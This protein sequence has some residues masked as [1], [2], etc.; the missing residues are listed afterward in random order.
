MMR[1]KTIFKIN[2]EVHPISIVDETKYISLN[3]YVYNYH[4]DIRNIDLTIAAT[5][6]ASEGNHVNF[7]DRY[8]PSEIE[9]L[10]FDKELLFQLFVKKM[11][12]QKSR[13]LFR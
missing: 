11:S 1:N 6:S 4:S 5:I 10:N 2:S 12:S 9:S 7:S 8:K 3:S 13:K